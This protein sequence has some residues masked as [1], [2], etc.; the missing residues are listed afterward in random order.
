V[1]EVV[2]L[3]IDQLEEM[4]EDQVLLLLEHQDRLHYQQLQE[5][6][7]FQHYRHQLE[8]VKLQHLQYLERLQ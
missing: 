6:T 2:E 7:Q 3:Q 8:D 4:Q 1:V 5:Q